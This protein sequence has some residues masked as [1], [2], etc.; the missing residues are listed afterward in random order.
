MV[1]GSLEGRQ[2]YGCMESKGTSKEWQPLAGLKRLK[3]E[4]TGAESEWFVLS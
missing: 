4:A 2:G 3:L 1:G